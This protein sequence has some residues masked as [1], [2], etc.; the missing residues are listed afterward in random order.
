MA[1]EPVGGDEQRLRAQLDR[2]D[3]DLNAAY[4]ECVAQLEGDDLER[5]RAAQRAWITFRD[6]HARANGNEPTAALLAVTARRAAEL[7]EFYLAEAPRK[8]PPARGTSDKA[9]SNV[10]DPFER[11]R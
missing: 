10:P 5:L 9:D 3:G 7:R 8:P 2:A 6:E 4:K 1:L 11:A